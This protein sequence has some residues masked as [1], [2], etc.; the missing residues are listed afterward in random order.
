MA[1]RASNNLGHV[2]RGDLNGQLRVEHSQDSAGLGRFLHQSRI[3]LT[4]ILPID[5]L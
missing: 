1:M 2:S 3:D 4:D 5:T